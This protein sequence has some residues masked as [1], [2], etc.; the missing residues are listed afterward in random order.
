MEIDDDKHSSK[1]VQMKKT[2][3]NLRK[4]PWTSRQ[5]P[6]EHITRKNRKW[7]GGGTMTK[8][9][10]RWGNGQIKTVKKIEKLDKQEMVEKRKGEDKIK[11]MGTNSNKELRENWVRWAHEKIKTD[12]KK[13]LLKS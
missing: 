2:C 13:N 11:H 5:R 7:G 1:T 8:Y 12:K 6:D 3:Y 10:I 9:L 4:C